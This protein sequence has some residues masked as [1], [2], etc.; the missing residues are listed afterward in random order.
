[1]VWSIGAIT[2]AD[3]QPQVTLFDE[4]KREATLDGLK[5]ESV[6]L[7]DDGNGAYQIFVGVDDENYGG[8]L[9]LLPPSGNITTSAPRRHR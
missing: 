8:T 4:P 7:G 2:L 6:A 1:M 9:R 5:V 3:G